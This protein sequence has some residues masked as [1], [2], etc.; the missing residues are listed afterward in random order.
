MV[1]RAEQPS[2]IKQG[3]PQPTSV[4]ALLLASLPLLIAAYPVR[5]AR[6]TL[7]RP[8][9]EGALA[10]GFLVYSRFWPVGEAGFEPD[11]V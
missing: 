4:V 7:R 11:A 3:L 1:E 5:C 8:Q 6:C 9:D 2:E 10:G